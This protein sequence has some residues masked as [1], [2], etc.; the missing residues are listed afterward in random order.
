M[1]EREPPGCLSLP[2]QPQPEPPTGAGGLQRQRAIEAP[3]PAGGG[4][5][6]RPKL[7]W[8]LQTQNLSAQPRRLTPHKGREGAWNQESAPWTRAHTQQ[9]ATTHTYTHLVFQVS[10]R[11]AHTHSSLRGHW[12]Q[13][14]ACTP[15]VTHSPVYIHT[16]HL[17]H[18]F[19][20]MQHSWVLTHTAHI[21]TCAHAQ[22]PVVLLWPRK[23][24]WGMGS[25]EDRVQPLTT[26]RPLS[27]ADDPWL[28]PEGKDGWGGGGELSSLGQAQH[29]WRTRTT[30]KCA[31]TSHTSVWLPRERWGGGPSRA[32]PSPAAP[33]GPP[34]VRS[35][36]QSPLP[37]P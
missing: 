14:C 1:G 32:D 15:G 37:P 2:A 20:F 23:R 29:T 3:D 6:R 5:F 33:S 8:D 21:H 7:F 9:H 18:T 10:H 11:H 17:T 34:G 27:H 28:H 22:A 30:T 12:C 36:L 19:T 24:R 35:Q 13:L 26:C 31:R 4:E 25:R 16:G